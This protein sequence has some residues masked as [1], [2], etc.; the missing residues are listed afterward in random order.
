MFV[1]LTLLVEASRLFVPPGTLP[2]DSRVVVMLSF[3]V[4]LPSQ[5]ALPVKSFGSH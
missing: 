1:L 4:F 3:D 2:K 5:K